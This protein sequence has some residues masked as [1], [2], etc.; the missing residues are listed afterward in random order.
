MLPSGILSHTLELPMLS[1]FVTLYTHSTVAVEPL[2]QSQVVNNTEAR[3]MF[4]TNHYSGPGSAHGRV[5]VCVS[6]RLSAR[7]DNNF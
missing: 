7:Q 6:M 3:L 1:S 2:R 5:C 4:I